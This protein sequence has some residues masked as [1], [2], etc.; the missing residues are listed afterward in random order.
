MVTVAVSE[1]PSGN[2]I[3]VSPLWLLI[4]RG[5][6]FG[7]ALVCLALAGSLI[8]DAYLDEEGLNVAVAV[9]T[10][11]AVAYIVLSEKIP[12]LQMA[13]HII[14]VLVVEALMVILWL[15]TF[16]ATA[17]RRSDFG[18]A[19]GGGGSVCYNGVCYSAK[20]SIEKRTTVDSFLSRLAGAA[21]LG[22]LVWL[23]FIASAVWTT[24]MFFKARKDGHFHFGSTAGAGVGLTT[25][26]QL[27]SKGQQP[28]AAVAA[29]APAPAPVQQQPQYPQDSYNSAHS[30]YPQGQ[31]TPQGQYSPQGQYPPQDGQTY[32]QYQQQPSEI[33][34]YPQQ[35]SEVGG[36]SYP[37]QTQSPAPGPTQYQQ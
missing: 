23:L 33:A 3:L 32:A 36:E 17:A 35:P 9:L 31:Y 20:R 25:E 10:W 7:L 5:F 8:S 18:S 28:A 24:L 30:T 11:L 2:H 16:A 13:Y 19:S 22:A 21:G 15:A 29:P 27:E 26:Y 1:K 14:A 4:V 12:A 34:Q 6:Q 37:P